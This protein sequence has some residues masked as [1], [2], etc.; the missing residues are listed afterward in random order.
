MIPWA[1]ANQRALPEGTD[2]VPGAKAEKQ[3]RILVRDSQ[4]PG[5]FLR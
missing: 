2:R 4:L 1:A 3:G 5:F